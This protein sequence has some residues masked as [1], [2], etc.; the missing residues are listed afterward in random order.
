MTLRLTAARPLAPWPVSVCCALFEPACH[1]TVNV[2][3]TVGGTCSDKWQPGRTA[4]GTSM[5]A[6][7]DFIAHSNSSRGTSIAFCT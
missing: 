4:A 3:D 5:G 1:D 7:C 6:G 2:N